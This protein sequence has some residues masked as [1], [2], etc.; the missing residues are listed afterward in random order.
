MFHFQDISLP[1]L[2]NCKEFL[3]HARRGYP[4]VVADWA[5]D[6]KYTGAGCCRMV[7]DKGIALMSRCKTTIIGPDFHQQCIWSKAN[8]EI[9]DRMLWISENGK[10]HQESKYTCSM[11]ARICC[12]QF[13]VRQAWRGWSCQ[14]FAEAFPFGY[15]KADPHW[16]DQLDR[17]N[18]TIAVMFDLDMANCF[19]VKKRA[20]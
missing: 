20:W 2:S 14:D 3:F 12:V 17:K 8:D 1:F 15:M 19:A 11:N 18:F 5:E 7:E 4:I 6:M 10:S 13:F 9:K 16:Q